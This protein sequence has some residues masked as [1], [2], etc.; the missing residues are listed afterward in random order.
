MNKRL[1][2]TGHLGFVG[3]HLLPKLTEE[4]Y[5]VETDM[6]YLH[7]RKYDC[8]IHLAGKNNIKNEFDADLIES[9]IILTREI[10]KV[11]TRIVYASSCVAHYPLNP[12]AYSKLY[13]EHLGAIHGNA[14]GLRLHN[15]YGSGNR[16]G[17]VYWLMQQPDKSK[18]T[19]RDGV[20]D[21]VHVDD[22]VNAILNYVSPDKGPY[23]KYGVSGFIR[24]AFDKGIRDVGTGV[25]TKTI[26][27]VSMYSRLS[28]KT[29]DIETIPPDASE[30]VS[31]ISDN[32]IP[33]ISLEDGLLKTINESK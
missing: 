33:H 18:I 22:V 8:V 31:M 3:S 1:F 29:F 30:P 15:C 14:L 2:L 32:V 9:N 4:G 23:S 11:N 10:F 26:D 19:I 20:R 12:Y 27:L 21:Y 5:E 25:G 24:V 6:R 28:G 16:K 7:S 13:A 17:I